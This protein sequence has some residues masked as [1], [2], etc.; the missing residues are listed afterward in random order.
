VDNDNFREEIT[1]KP[2]S[3]Y[4]YEPILTGPK[5]AKKEEFLKDIN[6]FSSNHLY[7]ENPLKKKRLLFFLS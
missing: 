2:Y 6:G 4:V 1:L 5:P 7:G 3:K